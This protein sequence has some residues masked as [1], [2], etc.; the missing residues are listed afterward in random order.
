MKCCELCS[1]PIPWKI[2]VDGKPRSLQNRRYCLICSPYK[3][4]N[5]RQLVD[6]LTAEQRQQRTV[7]S[8]R[9]KYRKYQRK[10]RHHRKRLLV[11][12]LGG[13]CQIC[14]Y[15]RDCPSA[16]DFHHRDP[17]TKVFEVGSRGLLRRLDEL[18][19][20]AGKCVLLCCRCHR[21]VHAGLHKDWQLRW[22]DR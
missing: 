21:E 11:E 9:T 17:A 12:M 13:C 22:K 1:Q 18:I 10:A 4:H 19:A 8:R 20:E 3:A 5:T 15:D 6:P 14:G 2:K 16:Y 7:E